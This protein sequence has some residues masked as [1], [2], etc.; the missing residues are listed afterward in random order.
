MRLTREEVRHIALLAR[1]GMTDSEVERMRD[2]LSHIFES[3]DVLRKVDT[4]GIDP[5][6]HSGDVD[7]V[8]RADSVVESSPVSDMLANAP[9]REDDFLKVRSVL[10]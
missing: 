6:G 8:M 5:T 10:E 9:S 2:Q 4:L 7:T 3:V 1:I